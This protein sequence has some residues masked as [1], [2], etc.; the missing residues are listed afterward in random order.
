MY[1][2]IAPAGWE[3]SE[4]NADLTTDVNLLYFAR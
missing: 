1:V 2:V 3:S 4:K